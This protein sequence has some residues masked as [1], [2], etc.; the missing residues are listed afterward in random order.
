MA[1]KAQDTATA[2]TAVLDE[3]EY[4]LRQRIAGQWCDRVDS[5]LPD[6]PGCIYVVTSLN[7]R[8]FMTFWEKTHQAPDSE[9]DEGR[10]ERYHYLWDYQRRQHLVK[11]WH[12]EGVSQ[13]QIED[14]TG[15]SL[16]AV[17]LAGMVINATM[18]AT[19]RAMN[20]PNLPGWWPNRAP[21]ATSG[22]A[23]G[24]QTPTS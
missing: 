22:G 21:T 19:I 16:P 9:T 11:A 10:L 7:V 6:F 3:A 5:P 20:L 24:D 18:P 13:A 2:E 8:Q 14:E 1:K 23:T 15:Q 12:V 17:E 4:P